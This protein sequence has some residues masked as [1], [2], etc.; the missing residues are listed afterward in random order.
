MRLKRQQFRSQIVSNYFL[1]VKQSNL[2]EFNLKMQK[3]TYEILL[4]F[5]V[6]YGLFV[7]LRLY[8]TADG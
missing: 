5:Y 7:A 8:L 4:S 2:T 6:A 3:T 1:Q